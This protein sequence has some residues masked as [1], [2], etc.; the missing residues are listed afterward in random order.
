VHDHAQHPERRAFEDALNQMPV[1]AAPLGA[2]R[3]GAL[4]MKS[5]RATHRISGIVLSAVVIGIGAV[6]MPHSGVLA[7]IQAM[8]TPVESAPRLEIGKGR[9]VLMMPA[10]TI[11]EA[12]GQLPFPIYRPDHAQWHLERILVSNSHADPVVES[13]YRTDRGWT[14]ITQRLASAASAPR[15]ERLDDVLGTPDIR[16][17][18]AKTTISYQHIKGAVSVLSFGT[19]RVTIASIPF[20]FRVVPAKK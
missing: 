2:V 19:T 14:K 5:R 10:K 6:A 3:A 13:L 7:A 17:Q 16:G 8:L 11:D 1:P 20:S 18:H 15:D 12:Q 9:L 4:L